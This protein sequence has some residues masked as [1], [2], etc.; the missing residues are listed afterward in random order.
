MAAV[1]EAQA[2]MVKERE[3]DLSLDEIKA[4]EVA[5]YKQ[6]RDVV[7]GDHFFL[8]FLTVAGLWH[9]V[10]LKAVE[11]Y[12]L[13]VVFGGAYLYLLSRYVGSIGEQNLEAA[14]EGGVGQARFAV[15]ALLVAVAGKQRA[16]LDFLPLLGGFFSYQVATLVQAAR[17]PPEDV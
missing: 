9:F 5:L 14:K 7:V 4:R 15:V 17:P 16:S 3:S 8:G 13:G 2:D 6:K 11:S 10:P 12:G 1:F